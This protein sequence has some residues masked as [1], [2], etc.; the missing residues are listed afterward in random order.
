M[1]GTIYLYKYRIYS[2][3][4]SEASGKQELVPAAIVT[5][6]TSVTDPSLDPELAQA[7][8]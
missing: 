4:F 5:I 8:T 3:S 7:V 2:N 1:H 6:W